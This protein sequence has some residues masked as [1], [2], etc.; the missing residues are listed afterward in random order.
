MSA[1]DLHDLFVAALDR[2]RP[3]LGAFCSRMAHDPADLEDALQGT[4]LEAWRGFDSF[5][6]GTNFRAW[7]L[8]IATWTAFGLNRRRAAAPEALADDPVAAPEELARELAYDDLLAAPERLGPHLS[9][10]VLRALG[11]L[12]ENERAIFLL[13]SLGGLTCAD[14]AE[15]LT[16]PVGTVMGLLARARGKLRGALADFAR[17]EGFLRKDSHP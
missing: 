14:V 16:L 2:E 4:L 7:L 8:R 10:E 17:R 15:I 13:K 9:D 3:V 11:G 6:P 12:T 5:R 1:R